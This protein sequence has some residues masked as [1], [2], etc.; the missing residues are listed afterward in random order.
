MIDRRKGKKGME[1]KVRWKG[2]TNEDDTWEPIENLQN[3]KA[4]VDDY[5]L[6]EKRRLEA[7]QG[8]SLSQQPD[9]NRAEPVRV[10]IFPRRGMHCGSPSIL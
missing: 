7:A 4:K 8:T 2:Y 6:R 3:A 10:H 5:E 1:Y 9:P